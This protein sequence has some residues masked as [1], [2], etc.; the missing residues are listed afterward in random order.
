MKTLIQLTFNKIQTLFNRQGKTP[1]LAALLLCFVIFLF[2]CGKP[3]NNPTPPVVNPTGCAIASD[4]DQALGLRNFEYDDKGLLIK[5]TAPNYYYGTFVRTVT[6]AKAVDAYPS[7]AVDGNGNHYSGT[8]NI[9][10][11][12]AGG[13]GNIYDG[14]PEFLHEMFVASNPPSSYKRDSLYQF[15]YDDAKKHLTTVLLPDSLDRRFIT[16]LQHARAEF[17]GIIIPAI[18]GFVIIID[19]ADKGRNIILNGPFPE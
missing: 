9:T 1:T 17:K 7:T 13:S 3:S 8:I 15:K 4:V 11:N 5:M 18:S 10:Y 12:Y 6:P 14:N 16:T 2:G 19:G